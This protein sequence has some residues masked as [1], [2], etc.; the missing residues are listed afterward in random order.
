MDT[1]TTPSDA[2]IDLMDVVSD[3]GTGLS[4]GQVNSLNDKLANALAS[5]DAGLNK[6][7]INQLQAFINSVES[8][9]KNGKIGAATAAALIAAATDI[10]G[11]L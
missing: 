4:T 1:T 5:I 6:Q 2:V 8:G 9:A 7:A 11:M 3:A 10:I